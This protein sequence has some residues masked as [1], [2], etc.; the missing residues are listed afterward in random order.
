MGQYIHHTLEVRP[1][2]LPTIS[3]ENANDAAHTLASPADF[4]AGFLK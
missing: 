4:L 3:T 1:V 2:Y